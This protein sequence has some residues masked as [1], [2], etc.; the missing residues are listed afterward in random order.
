MPEGV[1]LYKDMT[2][3]EFITY[4]AELKGVKRKILKKA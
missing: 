1:P 3:K 4:M 2:V